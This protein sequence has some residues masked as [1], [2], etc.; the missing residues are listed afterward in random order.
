MFPNTTEAVEAAR[1]AV[2]DVAAVGDD[3]LND[4]IQLARASGLTVEQRCAAVSA[5]RPHAHHHGT[6][7]AP[8][9]LDTACAHS[10]QHH[11]HLIVAPV[12]AGIGYPSSKTRSRRLDHVMGRTGSPLL[13]ARRPCSSPTA[14]D[15]KAAT[16]YREYDL[17]LRA[18]FNKVRRG[19]R[20]HGSGTLSA[21]AGFVCLPFSHPL[22]SPCRAAPPVRGPNPYFDAL[23]VTVWCRQ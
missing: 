20:V 4:G 7:V 8:P 2:V 13:A 14:C 10:V 3:D 17:F 12:C 1:R 6:M 15:I 16:A 11:S 9:A 21:A 5:L 18:S 22:T 19:Q 23:L